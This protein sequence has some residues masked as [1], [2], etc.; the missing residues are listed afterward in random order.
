MIKLPYVSPNLFLNK[1]IALVGSSGSLNGANFGEKIDFF[2][3][4]I[5]FNRAPTLGYET[6]VGCKTTL[7]VSNNHVFDNLDLGFEQYTNY[8]PKFIKDLRYSRILYIGD[9]VKP[10]GR[11]NENSHQTN[12][13]YLFD[14]KSIN[15]IKDFINANFQQNLLVGTIII[16]L[17]VMAGIRPTIFG[18]DL[19]LLP[20]T[21]YWQKRPSEADFKNHCPSEEIFIIKSLLDKGLINCNL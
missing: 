13:L 10:W 15:K 9:P 17:C 14:Y 18:Y 11:R 4:V 21:H 20:R 1:N 8:N 7:R 16:A 5:R 6:D 3:E 2:D 19:E 12:E